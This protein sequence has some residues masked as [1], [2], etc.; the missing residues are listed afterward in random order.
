MDFVQTT[1]ADTL[2]EQPVAFWHP[3][4]GI[5]TYIC[6]NQLLGGL[7]LD[8]GGS[9]CF[10]GIVFSHNCMLTVYSGWTF[11]TALSLLTL[12]DLFDEHGEAVWNTP[13]VAGLIHLFYLSK[14]YEFFDTWIHYMKGRKPGNLQM[15]HHIGAVL[16]MATLVKYRVEGAWIWLIFNSGVHTIMYCY[17][18]GATIGLRFPFKKWITVLQLTQFVAGLALSVWCYMYQRM[19]YHQACGIALNNAYLLVLLN[20]FVR[21]FSQSY[22]APAGGT[23][24]P[25][26]KTL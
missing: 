15:F 19:S 12:Q 3:V 22:G 26:G 5:A 11:Y 18:A 2:A 8:L 4:V 16:V 10:K 17:Y 1:L 14:Y 23:T 13:G 9:A 24:K 25:L 20:L 21:F 6:M 7:H